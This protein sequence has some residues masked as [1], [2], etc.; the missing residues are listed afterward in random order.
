MTYLR[1]W[2]ASGSL[3]EPSLSIPQ[4]EDDAMTVSTSPEGA[5]PDSIEV[6]ADRLGL[7][8]M[9]LSLTRWP[10]IQRVP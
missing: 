10:T 5:E 4:D 6:W 8:P 1:G 2:G 3:G 7:C 9:M